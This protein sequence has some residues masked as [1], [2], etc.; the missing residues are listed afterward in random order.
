M[1]ELAAQEDCSPRTIWRDLAAIQEAGFS[2]Y[3]EKSGQKSRWGFVV[4]SDIPIAASGPWGLRPGGSD[5]GLSSLKRKDR[6]FLPFS[7]FGKGK[8]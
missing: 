3:S 8:A 4:S 1:A 5:A 7:F 2:L 6:I